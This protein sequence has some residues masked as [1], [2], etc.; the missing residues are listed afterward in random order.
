V[1]N[2]SVGYFLNIKDNR[3]ETSAEIFAKT[4]SNLVEYKDF[5]ILFLNNHLETELL[6]GKGKAY[7]GEIYIR[8]LKGKWTGWASY[9]YSQTLVKVVSVHEEE[10]INKG[11]WFPS[12]YNK[13]HNLNLVLNRSLRKSSAFSMIFSYTTGRPFTAIESS[14]IV[15]DIVV[16]VYSERNKYKIPDYFRIDLSFTIGQVIKKLDGSLVFAV[17]NF[18][19]RDNA[20]S[21][22]YKRPAAN[23]FIPKPYKLSVLGA[24]LPS[25]TYNFKF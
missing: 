17:Y 9:T 12:N 13:P 10:S 21:V 7:G 16:P 11:K 23:Y 3:W 8:R 14:Y 4:M 6:T 2:F 24:A 20:Y 1:D 25:L 22:F 15:D 19:G 18:L 5:P